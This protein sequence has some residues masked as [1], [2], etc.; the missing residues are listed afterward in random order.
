MIVAGEGI[1]LHGIKYSESSIIVTMYTREWGR[2]AYI[3]NI[4][5]S[6]K[7]G[8]KA[9]MLQPLYMLNFV[10]YHKNTREIQR[11]KEIKNHP[12]YQSI[13][14]NSVKS[15]QV[16]FLAELLYRTLK[17]QDSSPETFEFVQNALQYYDLAADAIA[18]FHLWFLIRF[19][20]YVGIMPNTER[21]GFENYFD[22]RKGT[23]VSFEPSHPFFIHKEATEAFILL[24]TKK[25]HELEQVKLSSD[26]RNILTDKMVE[27]YQLHFDRMGE[28]KSMKVLHEVFS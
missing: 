21:A 9:G 14:F 23:V 11:I 6:R 5:R 15:V 19:A 3:M 20:S 2:Q 25:L 27:Y 12:V 28:I 24:S 10:A 8:N 4:S 13:P 22:M 26:L 16:I 7:S 18:N 1:V 17:E